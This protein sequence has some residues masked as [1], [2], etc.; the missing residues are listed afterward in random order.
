MSGADAGWRYACGTTAAVTVNWES[1]S[2]TGVDGNGQLNC[3]ALLRGE[4]R[5]YWSGAWLGLPG[6]GLASA[7]A[8]VP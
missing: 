2:N 4:A 5:R 3:E 6:L 8:F 1:G 7:H